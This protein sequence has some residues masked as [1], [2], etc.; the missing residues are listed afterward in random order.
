MALP[1]TGYTRQI[2][3]T[4]ERFAGRNAGKVV[5]ESL[6]RRSREPILWN[7][8]QPR[9]S[10]IWW[11]SGFEHFETELGGSRG[12]VARPTRV[13]LGVVPPDCQARGEFHPHELCDY[14]IVFIERDFI[15]DRIP[16]MLERPMVG[17]DRLGLHRGVGELLQW[18]DDATFCLMAEGWALQ[19]L[20]QLQREA[21]QVDREPGLRWHLGLGK[22]KR[23]EDYILANLQNPIVLSDLA[24]VAGM[25]VRHFT[26]CFRVTV[27]QTPAQFVFE[28]RLHTARMLLQIG[29]T[30]ITDVAMQCGFSHSQ[31]LS[32]SFRRRFGVTPSEF[33]LRGGAA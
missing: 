30:S 17:D 4:V 25:S 24:A 16:A 32:N 10:L 3:G 13:K 27:G 15:D 28:T 33:R 26:R 29:R 7:S 2:G 8:L 31:H 22:V 19:A 9:L 23:I 18:K 5:V 20:A 14:D 21:G 12:Q 1:E 11:K 6:T